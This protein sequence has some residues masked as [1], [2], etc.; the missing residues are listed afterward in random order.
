MRTITHTAVALP[1]HGLRLLFVEDQS[2]VRELFAALLTAAGAD[3]AQAST[4]RG[5]LTFASTRRFDAILSDLGLPDIAGDV[6][7]RHLLAGAA[8]PLPTVAV[9]TG[10]GEPHLARARAA[11]AQAVFQK[12]VEWE[13]ILT[14]LRRVATRGQ[15]VRPRAA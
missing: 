2:D 13:H 15:D 10:H 14:F 3:V 6:L 1:L 8:R 5:A 11:G 12:P 9:M 4:G 7:I